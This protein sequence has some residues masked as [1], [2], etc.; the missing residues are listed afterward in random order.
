LGLKILFFK[1]VKADKSLVSKKQKQIKGH[2][3][4]ERPAIPCKAPGHISCFQLRSS[5][6]SPLSEYFITECQLPTNG[7]EARIHLKKIWFSAEFTKNCE[8]LVTGQSS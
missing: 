7:K 4:A 5:R 2:P 3:L 6:Q 8:H 1:N